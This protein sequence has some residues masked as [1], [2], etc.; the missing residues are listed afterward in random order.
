MKILNIDQKMEQALVQVLDVALKGA[1]MQ[2][3]AS[4]DLI[5]NSI[6]EKTEEVV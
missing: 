5:R 1:G 4:V 2:I 6:V 3:L